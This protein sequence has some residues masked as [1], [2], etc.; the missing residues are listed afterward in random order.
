MIGG[1]QPG[2][3]ASV[4]FA[5]VKKATFVKLA[6]V[7]PTTVIAMERSRGRDGHRSKDYGLLVRFSST[8]S[9]QSYLQLAKP[10]TE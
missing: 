2:G 3:C 6:T 10:P 5:G 1:G 4:A 9:G 7:A 8:V